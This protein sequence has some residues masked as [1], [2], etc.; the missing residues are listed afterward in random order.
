[1]SFD[2]AYSHIFVKST[3]IDIS[4]ASGNPWF[5]GVTYIG[6]VV[7]ACR[8]RLGGDEISLGR[9]GGAGAEVEALYQG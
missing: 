1:M 9:A 2:L 8:H 4:A 7:V 3:H 6:D 5:D